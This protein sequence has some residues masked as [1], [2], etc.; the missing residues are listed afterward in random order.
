[1][2]VAALIFASGSCGCQGEFTAPL[3]ARRR[4]ERAM[5][6]NGQCVEEYVGGFNT[7]TKA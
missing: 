4:M 7:V 3:K 1:L 5:K 2:P 6:Q